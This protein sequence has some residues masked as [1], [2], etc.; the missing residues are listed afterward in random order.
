MNFRIIVTVFVLTYLRL[1][2]QS[3][4]P[5]GDPGYT[6]RVVCGLVAR[7]ID[8]VYFVVGFLKIFIH[9]R[10]LETITN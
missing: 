1:R 2:D 7:L 5:S 4:T 9:Q 10:M 3:W 8:V 6:E